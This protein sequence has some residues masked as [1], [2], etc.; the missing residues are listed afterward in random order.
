MN[1]VLFIAWVEN[2]TETLVA[3][4]LDNGIKAAAY[5]FQGS[6]DFDSR[7]QGAG[8]FYFL[9]RPR[10]YAPPLPLGNGNR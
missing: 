2:Q 7:R 4:F 1:L 5:S 9:I 8:E 10:S 3:K 6:L